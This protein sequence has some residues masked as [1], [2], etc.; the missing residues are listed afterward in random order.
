VTFA[1]ADSPDT[2]ATFS[3]PGSYVLQL[4]AD[5]SDLTTTDTVTVSL[6]QHFT[7][8]VSSVGPGDV[9]LDPPGASYPAGTLVSVSATPDAGAVFDGF[10]GDLDG[11]A[12]PQLLTVDGDK[13][14]S[15]SFSPESYTLSVTSVGPGTVTLDPPGG[16]Y[17][18]GTGVTLTAVPTRG[19]FFNGWS[20]DLSGTA[21]PMPLVVDAD[22]TVEA[23]FKSA[24]GSGTSCGIGPELVALLPAIGWLFR[25]RRETR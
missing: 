18:P 14:V 3:A 1:S 21:N 15:A 17:E 2:T 8:S 12:I 16:V 13:A 23:Q 22:Y 4:L 24:G 7:L 19:Y 5:D 10:G 20:G 11:T 9:T 25:R 6:T